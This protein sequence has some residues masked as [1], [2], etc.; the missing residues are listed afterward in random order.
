M[1]IPDPVAD[2]FAE[3]RVS[4]GCFVD[5]RSGIKATAV[6]CDSDLKLSGRDPHVHPDARGASMLE[7]VVQCFLERQK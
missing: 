4:I 5:H 2:A 1:Q 3:V 6:V 7:R